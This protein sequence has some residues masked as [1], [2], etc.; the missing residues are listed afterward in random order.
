MILIF[1]L[2]ARIK[3]LATGEFFC[4]HCGADRSYVLQQFRR[5][6]TLF[7]VPL[8]PVG[9]VLGENVKCTTCGSVFGTEVLDMPTSAA[10]SE[11]LG[12]AT[13]VAAMSMLAAGDPNN[14]AARL[15]AIDASRRAGA[16]SYDESWLVNDLEALDPSHLGEYLGPLAVG[17]DP[18]GKETFIEQIAR[19]GLADGPLTPTE[20]GVL[21]S[22]SSTLGLSAAHLRG[23]IVSTSSPDEYRRN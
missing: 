20:L 23:I 9:K 10:F 17:L 1:G 13:R 16:T 15:A 2:R 12:G 11:N 14:E 7:F 5:W 6:F 3:A 18:Q 22:L 21:E 19:I 4:T 8:F